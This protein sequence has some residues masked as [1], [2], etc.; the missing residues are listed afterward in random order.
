MLLLFS[1]H[2]IFNVFIVVWMLKIEY[3]NWCMQQYHC[4]EYAKLVIQINH[5][6]IGECEWFFLLLAS[7]QYD[8]NLLS[9]HRQYRQF[10]S[11]EFWTKKKDR[12][13]EEKPFLSN[14]WLICWRIWMEIS[15]FFF[16]FGRQHVIVEGNNMPKSCSKHMTLFF[17]AC[18]KRQKA[19]HAINR[20]VFVVCV[21]G[22][23]Q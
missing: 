18:N 14:K 4:Y 2:S 9:G 3:K 21:L 10:N 23:V 5:I 6:A 8:G 20:N 15:Y 7:A 11:I 22:G 19:C 17:I 13:E 1:F 12:E 16:L